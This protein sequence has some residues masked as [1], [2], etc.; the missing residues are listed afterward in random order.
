MRYFMTDA[1]DHTVRV[2][3]P[4]GSGWYVRKVG[5]RALIYGNG[6]LV[7]L[8]EALA[9]LYVTLREVES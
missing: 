5:P 8:A 2:R 7:F 4:L 9:P 1:N 6:S 3:L